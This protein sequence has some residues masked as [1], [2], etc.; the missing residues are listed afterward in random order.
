MREEVA[1]LE[2]VIS[3]GMFAVLMGLPI[4]LTMLPAGSKLERDPNDKR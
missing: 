1:I 2:T 3:V 4:L